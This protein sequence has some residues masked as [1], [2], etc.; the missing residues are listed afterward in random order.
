MDMLIKL[1]SCHD[2]NSTAARIS[3]MLELVLIR[4]NTLNE[5]MSAHFEFLEELVKQLKGKITMLE[6]FV[7][8][9]I[10]VVSITVAELLLVTQSFKK[11]SKD[12]IKWDDIASCFIKKDTSLPSNNGAGTRANAALSSCQV[13]HKSN[14]KTEMRS[15]HNKSQL[16]TQRVRSD[17]FGHSRRQVGFI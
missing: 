17:H 2:S 5:N 16:Q 11:S 3:I 13:L 10:L 9:G 7:A 8:I 6:D 14:H 1:D 12:G 4:Y 15:Q